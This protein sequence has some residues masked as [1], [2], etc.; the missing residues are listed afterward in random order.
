MRVYGADLN[1]RLPGVGH[2]WIAASRI[3]VTNGWALPG[4]VEVMHSPGAAGIASNY[5]GYGDPGS[6]GSGALSNIALLYENSVRGLRG[7]PEGTVPDLALSVF[8]MM[9]HARRD[10]AIEATMPTDLEQLKWG[11]DVTLKMLPWLA[12]MLRYD[13]VDLDA[14]SSG[15]A[16]RA[17]TPRVTFTSHALATESIWL[18]YSRYFYDDD[19]LLPTSASQPYPGPDRNVVKLQANLS[20]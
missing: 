10:L 17:L 8:G 11:T 15:G 1:L 19:V 6:T 13:S 18:Q 4:I 7:D 20:F 3:N 9:V 5:L 14:E 12:V 16:F 2:A